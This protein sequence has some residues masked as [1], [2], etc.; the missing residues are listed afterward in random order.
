MYRNAKEPFSER[1]K[2][3]QLS[4]EEEKEW[5]KFI[6]KKDQ[7]NKLL[8][9]AVNARSLDV[10]K[11]LVEQAAAEVNVKNKKGLTVLEV[12]KGD[13]K[14]YLDSKFLSSMTVQQQ[15]IMA[16]M[17]GIRAH[18]DNLSAQSELVSAGLFSAEKKQIKKCYQSLLSQPEDGEK[19]TEIINLLN[20]NPSDALKKSVYNSLLKSGGFSA[21]QTNDDILKQISEMASETA[22][23]MESYY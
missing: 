3:I 16:A 22:K 14:T 23:K 4:V 12:A 8:H 1:I 18:I 17:P 10:V 19:I 5:Q 20:G 11:W 2:T 21:E 9:A 13:V 6:N 15:V 7:A